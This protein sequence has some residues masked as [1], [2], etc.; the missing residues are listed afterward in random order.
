MRGV[1]TTV[2][3]LGF[4]AWGLWSDA[5]LLPIAALASIVVSITLEGLAVAR[6][7]ASAPAAWAIAKSPIAARHIV[8]AVQWAV[9]TRFVLV[10]LALFAGLVFRTHGWGLAVTLA[11]AG[12]LSARLIIATALAV[13]PSYPLDD[14]PVLTG[15]LGQV[16]AYACGI[17]G[18]I[19]YVI[20][21]TLSQLLGIWGTALVA[22]GTAGIGAA[23]IAAQLVAARRVG[24]L[25]H[26][27]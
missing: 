8:R 7:S 3:A 27:G 9:L 20:A 16:V 25:E 12:L 17:A 6:Q 5:G 1:V 10:P 19:A 26:A 18:A 13:R 2:L 14:V 11:M 22:V 23:S 15:M 4:A 24:R 21:A